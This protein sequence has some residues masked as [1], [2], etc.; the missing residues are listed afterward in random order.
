MAVCL[1]VEQLA[2][3]VDRD[4][5]HLRDVGILCA[6]IEQHAQ[7]ELDVGPH[8]KNAVRLG[9]LREDP[10]EGVLEAGACLG[11]VGQL[12]LPEHLLNDVLVVQA[13]VFLPIIEVDGRFL[14]ARLQV[15]RTIL[16]A[17]QLLVLAAVGAAFATRA[18]VPHPGP[19]TLATVA[20]RR[21]P[22][23]QVLRCSGDGDD[24]AVLLRRP[25]D[26]QFHLNDVNFHGRHAFPQ[27][28]F[29]RLP[30][31]PGLLRNIRHFVV[32]SLVVVERLPGGP[33]DVSRWKDNHGPIVHALV[34]FRLGLG[35][36]QPAEQVLGMN[37]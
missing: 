36:V 30:L 22:P 1:R 8:P 2:Q 32:P 11:F 15:R 16:A 33:V 18:E 17:W 25:E 31:G 7:A 6:T 12:V 20:A 14:L 37:P 13:F 26:N 27:M 4:R 19:P 29:K 24:G 35:V 3:V 23:G 9:E 5:V 10:L 21:V 34:D 28:L